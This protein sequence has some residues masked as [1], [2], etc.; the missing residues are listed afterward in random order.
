MCA[1]WKVM[2]HTRRF[3]GQPCVYK[4]QAVSTFSFSV[5]LL[6][7]VRTLA[8]EHLLSAGTNVGVWLIVY[9]TIWKLATLL[10]SML[11]FHLLARTFGVC[12]LASFYL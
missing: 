9:G 2:T 6:V 5:F 3:T 7:P 4:R 11:A 8:H 12:N 10:I 1:N